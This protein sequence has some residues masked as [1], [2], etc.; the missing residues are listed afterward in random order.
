MK[1]R[2]PALPAD[3][4]RSRLPTGRPASVSACCREVLMLSVPDCEQFCAAVSGAYILSMAFRPAADMSN[5]NVIWIYGADPKTIK[6]HLGIRA[7]SQAG[8]HPAAVQGQFGA[9]GCGVLP[10]RLWVRPFSLPGTGA[11]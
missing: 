3:R 1:F 8:Q 2:F 11:C 4:G 9:A 7:V 6:G 10:G 5:P